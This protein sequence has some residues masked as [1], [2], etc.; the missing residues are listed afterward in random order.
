VRELVIGTGTYDD[1]ELENELAAGRARAR[2][3]AIETPAQVAAATAGA[4]ALIVTTNRLDSELVAALAPSVRIVGRAGIGLDSIDLGACARAGVAVV[5]QPD[6]ATDEVAT[7]AIAL[8]LGLQ[9]RLLDGDRIARTDW[10][11]Y[12][13]LYDIRPLQELTL[14]LVGTGRI[15]RAVA[16]RARP[17]VRSVRAYDPYAGPLDGVERD[18]TLEQLLERS[19]IVSLHV[20]LTPE[21]AHLID[22]TTLARF[23]PGA[24]L[25]NVSRGGLVDSQ[26][27]ADALAAGRLA[28]A[29]LDVFEREPLDPASALARS[30]R[31]LLSPHMA[32]FS[33]SSIM[34]VRS[35]TLEDVL[36]FL[37]DG[38][39]RHGNLILPG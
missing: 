37:D 3:V 15:G 22:A 27:L 23:R 1:A 28:G 16:E 10:A 21:T 5:S 2:L 39:V 38:T 32:W 19:D 26:A 18:D 25:V 11:A 7:H 14:G 30:P 24:L 8:L 36:S 9:R 34:R 17:L 13:G 12:H 35:H 4:D 20:P 31:T 6:Y 29:A 33:T